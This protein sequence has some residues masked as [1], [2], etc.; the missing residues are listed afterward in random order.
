[1]RSTIKGFKKCMRKFWFG[2]RQWRE[3]G[4]LNFK[5]NKDEKTFLGKKEK[6]IKMDSWKIEILGQ[7][8]DTF[9]TNL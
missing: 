1:M 9:K 2:C 6:E 8:Y 7:E 5:N 4:K 3:M